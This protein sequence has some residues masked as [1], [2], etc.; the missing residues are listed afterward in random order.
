MF[1]RV[2]GPLTIL[3]PVMM[4]GTSVVLIIGY[5]WQDQTIGQLIGNV[6]EGW[7]VAVSTK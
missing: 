7:P 5:S 1:A 4:I 3:L 6:G 2:K